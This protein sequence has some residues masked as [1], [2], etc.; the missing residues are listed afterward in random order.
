MWNRKQIKRQGKEAFNRN[1]GKSITVC[2]IVAFLLGSPIITSSRIE[3]TSANQ[4]NLQITLNKNINY[5]SHKNNSM[6]VNDFI[7]GFNVIEKDNPPTFKHAKAGVLSNVV[8]NISKSSSYLFG[9]LNALNQLIFKDKIFAGIIITIGALIGFLYWI[10]VGNVLEVGRARFFLENRRYAKTKIS[11][12]LFTYRV[13]KTWNVASAMF[14]KK[15]YYFFWCFTGVGAIVKRYSY[16]LVPYILAE[17]PNI[18]GK[19]AIKLSKEMMNGYK[20][21]MFLIDLSFIGWHILGVMSLNVSNIIYTNPYKEATKAEVYMHLRNKNKEK[22]GL[23]A[24]TFSDDY[25]EGSYSDDIYPENLYL[26]KEHDSRKWMHVN[27]DRKYSLTDLIL[28]F[29]SFAAIGWI[30]EVLLRL[31]TNGDFVNRGTLLGPWLPIYG[32]GGVL[33]LILLKPFRK[34]PIVTFFTAMFV[35]GLVEYATGWYL[36][37]R[38]NMNWWDYNGYFLNINGRVCL[39]ALL[40]FAL[41]GCAAIY[42]AA[43]IIS[44]WFKKIKEKQKVILC[45]VLIMLMIGDFY[46]SGK[47]PNT[48][49]GISSPMT[50]ER[51]V[52]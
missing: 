19:Q 31:F 4:L 37:W 22:S 28:L 26:Y 32:T 18:K 52:K 25:L 21:K 50:E 33:V 1:F 44:E 35:C 30:W 20:W 46:Y 10:L 17:N 16:L 24:R 15:I 41:G 13:K 36:E 6:I 7:S 45:I 47:N 42:I 43:P 14:R 2:L 39:E 49:K 29:F 40:V 38:H 11:K 27:Y 51:N 12:I 5:F 34:K 9:L 8:N 23:A 48:G 3:E